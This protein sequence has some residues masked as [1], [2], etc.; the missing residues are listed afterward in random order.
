MILWIRKTALYLAAVC[1]GS[2]CRGAPLL[3]ALYAGEV[4]SISTL[5][6]IMAKVKSIN[7]DYH[8]LLSKCMA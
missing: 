2:C 6:I 5:K 4:A 8:W 3:R 1:A 7:G